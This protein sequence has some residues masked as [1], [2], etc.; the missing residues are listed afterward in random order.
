MAADKI[1]VKTYTL[2]RYPKNCD[3]CPFYSM[4]EYHCHNEYAT[5]EVCALGYGAER[6]IRD[7]MDLFQYCTIKEDERVLAELK[8]EPK[9]TPNLGDPLRI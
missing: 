3:E 1:K 6:G 4:L 2:E 7:G 5:E 9:A 8:D